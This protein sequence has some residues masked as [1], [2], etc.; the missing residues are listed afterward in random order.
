VDDQQWLDRASAQTLGFVALR[1]VADPVGLVLAARV[2][3]EE[4]A[5]LP[6]L[7][8]EG[9]REGDARAAL[10]SALTGS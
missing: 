5:G 1:L 6:E 10:D 4:L 7:A 9:L 8:V 3:A 2:P